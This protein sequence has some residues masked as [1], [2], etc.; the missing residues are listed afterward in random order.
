VEWLTARFGGVADPETRQAILL[1][2]ATSRTETAIQFLLGV[3]RDGSAQTSAMAVSAM[4]VN[5]TDR[6]IQG[7]V[8]EAIRG[9]GTTQA[10]KNDGLRHS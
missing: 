10:T 5:R 6:R 2:L 8:E 4:E 9:R 3:I 7:E 1:A